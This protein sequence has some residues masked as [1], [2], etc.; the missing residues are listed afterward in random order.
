MKMITKTWILAICLTVPCL[1]FAQQQADYNRKG[2]EA[3]RKRDYSDARLYY[4]EGVANCDL[5]SIDRLTELWKNN[6]QLHSSLHNL[7]GRCLNCLNNSAAGKDTAAIARLIVYYSA[8]IGAPKS[9]NMA[10]IWTQELDNLKKPVVET[11]Q[12]YLGPREEIN[13]IR[14]FAGYAF[15][16]LAPVGITVGGMGERFGLYGRFKTNAS[17]QSYEGEM[18]YP[19]KDAPPPS[20]GDAILHPGGENW[21]SLAITAGLVVRCNEFLSV[22]AGAGYFKMDKIF[23]YIE[24]DADDQIVINDK[25]YFKVADYSGQGIAVELDGIIE[26]GKLYIT[27]GIFGGFRQNATYIDVNAG[28]GF[29]F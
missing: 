10:N 16:V 14:Y 9:E 22:S 4:S 8:G 18:T 24:V 28:F 15:S 27:A 17:F 26:I 1:T 13:P 11:Q 20:I 2:D 29:F 5:Y 19:T 25:R 3:M 12:P 23:R 7:M 6:P 21:N